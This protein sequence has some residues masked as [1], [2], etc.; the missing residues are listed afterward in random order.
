MKTDDPKF[1]ELALKVIAGKASEP[2]QAELKSLLSQPEL[3]EEFK[4]LKADTAFAK[5]ALPLL[6]DEPVAV[7]PLTDFELSQMRKLAEQRKRRIAGEN[8]KTSWS[9][10]WVWGLAT[11]TAVVAIVVLLN[12]PAQKA[13]VQFAMLDSMGAMRGGTND[14]TPK[15]E[16]ALQEN[17]GQTNLITCSGSQELNQW[18]DQWPAGRTF[19]LVYDRDNGEVRIM[20]RVNGSTQILNTVP[21]AKEEDLPVV[22]KQ[23]SDAIQQL[24]KSK[25]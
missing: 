14:V 7:P 25:Q 24:S 15:L 17:F 5:E 13:S 22:M 3:A 16:A 19:K 10:R 9:W 11:A 21:V 4:Q 8:K 18:L 2:E 23:A 1:T 12:L 6:G 20:S